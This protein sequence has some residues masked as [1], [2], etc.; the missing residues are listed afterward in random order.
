MANHSVRKN[1]GLMSLC[2]GLANV[3][4]TVV[5]SVSAL[6]GYMLAEDKSL[7]T[8]PHALM[9]TATMATSPVAAALFRRL[10]RKRGFM[11]GA[12]IGL[13]SSLT[14]AYAIH[15]GDYWL[16]VLGI[17][18]FGAFNGFTMFYR[19]AAAEATDEA[20]RAKAI[21]LVIG[22]GVIAAFVGGSLADHTYDLLR[23]VYMGT[24]VSLAVIPFL[25]ILTLF[26]IDF[27]EVRTETRSGPSRSLGEIARQP[28]F[29]VAVL[30]GV[31]AWASMVLIMTATP[32]AMKLS[33]F[34]F[35]PYVTSV[36]QW[37]IF[38]MFAP[39]FFSGWL[40][41]RFGVPNV[42]LAGL[43]LIALSVVVG[44]AGNTVAHFWIMN[45]LIGAGWNFLFVGATELL[46]Q[47]HTPAERD[48][49]QGLNDFLAFG[50]VAMA[51]FLSGYV[52]NA[53]GWTAVNY[54]NIPGIRLVLVAV[55]WLRR[56][57]APAAAAE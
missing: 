54:L 4:V 26:F 33:G 3:S 1:V 8:L 23:T 2:Q 44:V 25:M 52:H 24:F 6:T 47:C 12:L 18:L 30:A 17:M 39:S 5:I 11:I 27:P 36:I 31:L 55:L 38:A 21:A 51:S 40:I 7:A 35:R 57:W 41:G 15:I 56:L 14:A 20:F 16:F 32:I 43:L 48:K 29:V 37:H 50:G 19:F 53:V 42:M 10:G 34:A 46:S 22:G 28:R 9:W 13:C 45:F 49:V